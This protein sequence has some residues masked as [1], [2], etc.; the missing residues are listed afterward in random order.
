MITPLN[1]V[2]EKKL[3]RIRAEKKKYSLSWSLNKFELGKYQI[4]P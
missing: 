4:F 3:N 1:T 2:R